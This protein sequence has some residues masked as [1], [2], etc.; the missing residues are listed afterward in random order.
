MYKKI[1]RHEVDKTQPIYQPQDLFYGAKWGRLASA[2]ML[3]PGGVLIA[4]TGRL[5]VDHGYAEKR[6]LQVQYDKTYV[7]TKLR[8]D[9]RLLL[10]GIT[11]QQ[12]HDLLD[13][14]YEEVHPTL[15]Q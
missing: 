6:A 5:S 7:K 11:K 8:R 15:W 9:L 10:S 14:V 1:E 3:Q 13:E 12:L 2:D 4:V